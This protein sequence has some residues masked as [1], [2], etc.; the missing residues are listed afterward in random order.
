M[1]TSGGDVTVKIAYRE[2]R[3]FT[4]TS[5]TMSLYSGYT[6]RHWWDPALDGKAMEYWIKVTRE[7]VNDVHYA[8]CPAKYHGDNPGKYY[9]ITVR[10]G[11]VPVPPQKVELQE[12]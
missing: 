6:Y 12:G 1:G 11:S 8:T 10:K 9:E 5:D 2:A 4:W 7:N 3:T